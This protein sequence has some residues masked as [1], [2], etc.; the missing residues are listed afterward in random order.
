MYQ[1]SWQD[2]PTFNQYSWDTYYDVF[3][4]GAELHIPAYKYLG[5]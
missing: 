1:Y 5:F 3:Y 2:E 4:I